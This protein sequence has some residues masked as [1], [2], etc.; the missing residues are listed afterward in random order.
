MR[1]FLFLAALF[2]IQCKISCQVWDVS[3]YD[4]LTMVQGG[5]TEIGGLYCDTNELIV[6]GSYSYVNGDSMLCLSRFD[7]VNWHSMNIYKMGVASPDFNV[8]KFGGNYT[9]GGGFVYINDIPYVKYLFQYDG[10]NWSAV[11]SYGSPSSI[12]ECMAL[13]NNKLYIG[14]SFGMIGSASYWGLA[15][16]DGDQWHNIGSVSGGTVRAMEVYKG[17]LY[18][19]GSIYSI[20]GVTGPGILRYDGSGWRSVGGGVGGYIDCL[21]VDSVENILYAGGYFSSAGGI[22]VHSIA[23]WDGENWHDVGGGFDTD[24]RAFCRYKGSIYVGFWAD[25]AQGFEANR[26]ARWDGCQWH[27]LDGDTTNGTDWVVYALEVYKDAL[28]VGG[29]YTLAG[30]IPADGLARWYI[31]NGSDSSVIIP[32]VSCIEDTLYLT[33]GQVTA[34]F[35]NNNVYSESW[36]WD[37][38][39]S[40]VA[41]VQ[42]PQHTFTDTGTYNVCVTVAY[43]GCVKTACKNITVL[44]SVETGEYRLADETYNIYP[45]PSTGT[46]TVE[47]TLPSLKTGKITVL[48]ITGALKREFPLHGGL[49]RFTFETAGWAKGTYVCSLVVEG[50][51]VGMRKVVVE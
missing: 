50:K 3:F 32:V 13:Y 15:C 1:T 22:P 4:S 47:A 34:Q 14:G 46:V 12:V 39:D 31:E 33:D 23:A 11:G 9:F 28:Y 6:F 41:S 20:S 5:Q 45:N 42:N 35:Y 36:Q 48:D 30:G 18:A 49:N 7:S 26:I 38:G 19:A 51:A 44:L 16:W 8:K 21:W 17:E 24:I 37:F 25:D 27:T 29:N 10:Q 2:L 40:G 43:Q